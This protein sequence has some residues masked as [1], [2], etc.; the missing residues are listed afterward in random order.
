MLA[1]F[2]PRR[3]FPLKMPRDNIVRASVYTGELSANMKETVTWKGF[4][5]HSAN[6][7]QGTR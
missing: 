3:Y 1:V 5:T 4:I 7:S 6:E 2:P